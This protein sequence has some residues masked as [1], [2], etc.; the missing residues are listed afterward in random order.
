ME[1]AT[2]QNVVAWLCHRR[3][4]LAGPVLAG[5]SVTLLHGVRC[6]GGHL[7]FQNAVVDEIR[8]RNS[9]NAKAIVT[10]EFVFL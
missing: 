8:S 2:S 5:R 6:S 3:L 9:S 1:L 4:C 10:P 7:S